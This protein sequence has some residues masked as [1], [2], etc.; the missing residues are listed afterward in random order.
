MSIN[1]KKGGCVNLSKENPDPKKI[2]I[3]LGWDTNQSDRGTEFDLDGLKGEKMKNYISEEAKVSK[4]AILEKPVYIKGRTTIRENS[5]VDS[6]TLI[7]EDSTIHANTIIGKYCSIG[8]KVEVGVP[9]HP[10]SRLST[11]VISFHLENRFPDYNSAFKQVEFEIYEDTKIGND[12]WIGSLV[13]IKTGV[14][15]GDGVIVGIG[16]IVTKD[17]PP[18]AIVM[19]VPATIRGYRFNKKTIK[20]L[21]ALK[22][23]NLDYKLLHDIEFDNIDKAIKQ[24]EELRGKD[25]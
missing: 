17:I 5:F 9:K 14:T 4:E 24:L 23:W 3:G 21:L 18:Y 8:K 2:Q 22:W 1:L 15:I 16:A 19:G 11:S 12:V 25:F 7:N 10:L 20:K 13:G 6:F